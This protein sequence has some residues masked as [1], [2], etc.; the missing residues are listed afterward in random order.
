[1]PQRVCYESIATVYGCP[2]DSGAPEGSFR[3]VWSD[4]PLKFE[5]IFLFETTPE[6]AVGI[7]HRGSATR[8]FEF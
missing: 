1:M 3:T 8:H 2:P 5:R 6:S 7:L 4:T